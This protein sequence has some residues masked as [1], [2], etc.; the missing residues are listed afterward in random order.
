MNLSPP[1]RPRALACR[2]QHDSE[3]DTP[4]LRGLPPTLWVSADRV[5][6][7]GG[8]EEQEEELYQRSK[9]EEEAVCCW[10]L[11]YNMTSPSVLALH[12]FL[13]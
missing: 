12:G 6:Q 5:Q 13:I 8:R 2:A 4:L 7:E 3:L 9:E 10:C 1:L 11:E